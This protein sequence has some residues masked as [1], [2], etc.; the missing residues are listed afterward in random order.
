M[1]FETVPSLDAFTSLKETAPAVLFYYS[2][3][4]CGV[5]QVLKPKIAELFAEHFPEVELKY[6]DVKSTPDIAAQNSVL[7]VP[8]MD[9]FLQGQSFMRESRHIS[10][11][12]LK[13]KLMRPYQLLFDD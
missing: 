8:T 1:S 7:T 11:G 13:D 12:A 5:C 10:V 9:V 3:D 2:H 4:G 6:V